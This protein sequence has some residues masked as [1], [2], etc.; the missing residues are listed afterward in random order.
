MALLS[1]WRVK[2]LSERQANHAAVQRSFAPL[3]RIV[4]LNR[5]LGFGTG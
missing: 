3:K 4:V 2:V 5:L 1:W